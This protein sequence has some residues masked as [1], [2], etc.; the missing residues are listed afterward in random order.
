MIFHMNYIMYIFKLIKILQIIQAEN[1]DNC[2]KIFVIE[3]HQ[4]IGKIFVL[5]E[6]NEDGNLCN[7]IEQTINN[8]NIDLIIKC[9]IDI[10][11]GL[12][13]LSKYKYMHRDIKPQ[14]IVFDGTKFK[15]ID[16][17]TSKCYGQDLTIYQSCIGTKTCIAPEIQLQLQYSS[18]CDIWSVGCVLYYILYKQFPFQ[19]Y[20]R[21]QILKYY[22]RNEML[23]LPSNLNKELNDLLQQMLKPREIDRISIN[24]LYFQLKMIKL[25]IKLKINDPEDNL[26]SFI[27]R[28]KFIIQSELDQD[29]CKKIYTCFKAVLNQKVNSKN[30]NYKTKQSLKIAVQEIIR[31]FENEKIYLDLMK[32][33]KQQIQE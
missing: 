27:D 13:Q 7:F 25:L 29:I 19:N 33:I 12:L 8:F 28:I 32:L 6:Y 26:V 16:F 1:L 31:E 30:E 9:L 24:V 21:G 15:L 14:N 23:K 18:K 2:V 5:E 22:Q 3:S 17:E 20:D 11:K 10:I 4:D